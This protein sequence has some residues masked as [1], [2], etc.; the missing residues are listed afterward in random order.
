MYVYSGSNNLIYLNY[1]YFNN[2]S[3]NTYDSSHVQAYDGGTNNHWNTSKY[4][5][6]WLDWAEN[7][8]TNDQNHDGIVDWPYDIKGS[9]GAKDYYP[10]KNPESVPELSPLLIF[11]IFILFA[12]F[13]KLNPRIREKMKRGVNNK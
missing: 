5:N 6:Y 7:N 9:A 4:G 8:D 11:Q 13:T 12:I 2:G 3:E 1:F 10:L